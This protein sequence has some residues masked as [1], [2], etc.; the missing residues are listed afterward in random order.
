V[1]RFTRQQLSEL[2]IRQ[3]AEPGSTG[4]ATS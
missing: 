1:L 4:Y 3:H 2:R